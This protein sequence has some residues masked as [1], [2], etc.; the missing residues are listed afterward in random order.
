MT[1]PF[2][3]LTC[4]VLASS[5]CHHA[6]T[7][8]DGGSSTTVQV[9]MVVSKPL[10]TKD[11]LPAQLL[12][13]EEV[14]IY[15]RVT[16]F[17]EELRVD[18]GSRVKKGER[19]ARLS[20]P[21]LVSQRAQAEAALRGV[22]SQVAMA[23]AKLEADRGTYERLG[24]AAKTPGVVAGNDLL[25][26]QHTVEGDAATVAAA[27]HQVSAARGAL[28]AVTQLESYLEIDAPFAGVVAARNLHP[29]ALVGPAAGQ[30]GTHP[31]VRVVDTDR[32]RLVVPVPEAE[33]GVAKLGGDVA[34]TVPGH[35][36]HTFHAPIARVAPDIDARTRTMRIE[37]DVDN[38]GGTLAPGAFATVTWIV[39]RTEPSLFVPSTAV[40]SDQQ[41]TFVIRV[42]DGAAHWVTVQTGKTADGEIEVVGD[43]HAGDEV[44]RNATDSIR[45]GQAVAVAPSRAQ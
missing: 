27:E 10:H 24:G 16:G 26:S 44:V 38:H 11:R 21:E 22:E 5:G 1:R 9:T 39:E 4:V 33:V 40:A 20:A 17:V 14:D 7:A 23:K 18:V 42:I 19:M 32:L 41:R 3:S 13:F 2:L 36:G 31:I 35:L 8:P 29:G 25:V 12:P 28:R 15:P 37:G 45:D 6:P 30:A 34:F 43:L